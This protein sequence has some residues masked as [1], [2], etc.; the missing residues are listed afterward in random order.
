MSEAKHTFH[1]RPVRD[2]ETG[3]LMSETDIWG[4]H[5]EAADLKEFIEV[6]A[7]FA[8]ELIV[9]NHTAEIG[10]SVPIVVVHPIT[11]VALDLANAA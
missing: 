11:E 2:A 10:E 1:V 5:I 9:A 4:L 7:E 8:Q 3:R 6:V